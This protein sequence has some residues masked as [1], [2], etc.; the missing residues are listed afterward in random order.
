MWLYICVFVWQ[1]KSGIFA[2]SHSHITHL[3]I[4]RY[5]IVVC[6]VVA[7]FILFAIYSF[8]EC[9]ACFF[10]SAPHKRWVKSRVHFNTFLFWLNGNRNIFVPKSNSIRTKID[11][12]NIWFRFTKKCKCTSGAHFYHEKNP[13]KFCG[14]PMVIGAKLAAKCV[15]WENHNRK[16]IPDNLQQ[17]LS[18]K[19]FTFGLTVLWPQLVFAKF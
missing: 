19:Q 18:Q 12:A 16:N 3:V 4:Y 11:V 7:A 14:K 5:A 15:S 9:V 10:L 17:K 2:L 13:T 6:V 8:I 1:K